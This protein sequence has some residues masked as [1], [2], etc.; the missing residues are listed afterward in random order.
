MNDLQRGLKIGVLD[1]ESTALDAEDGRMLCACLKTVLPGG[2]HG[3][4]LTFKVKEDEF[5]I[6]DGWNDKRITKE[7]VKAMD[8]YDLILTWYGS[9][10]DLPFINT[11]ALLYKIKTPDRNFRRDLCYVSK[12]SLK[13]KNNR[14]ATVGRFFFGKSGKSF[15]AW[16]IW[17]RAMRGCMDSVDYIV[18]HCQKDVLETEKI[19]KR[20]MPVL[21]KLRKR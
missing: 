20:I 18:D 17:Q 9:Q 2:L 15:L 5:S 19:Y 4:T 16:T 11:R 8:G 13:L 14:L 6:K 12:G 7:L 10:F 21:G 3:E 1:I